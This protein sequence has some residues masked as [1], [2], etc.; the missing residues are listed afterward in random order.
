MPSYRLC[1]GKRHGLV[2]DG[3]LIGC[4]LVRGLSALYK[5]KYTNAGVKLFAVNH[6]G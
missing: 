1:K 4:Q 2:V 3:L 5:V 6:V